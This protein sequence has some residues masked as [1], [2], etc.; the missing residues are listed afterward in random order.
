MDIINLL[1]GLSL[2]GIGFLTK[3]SPNLIAGYNTMP[4]D[5]K[6]NVDIEGLSTYLRN[7]FI[8]IG[9]T[10]IIGYFLF[11]WI[12]FQMIANS[13]IFISILLGVIILVIFAQ[14]YDHNKENK[15]RRTY[16]ILGIVILSVLGLITY[17][18]VPTKVIVSNDNVR[19]KGIYGFEMR[20]SDIKNIELTEKI[21]S[22]IMR[23]NGFGLGAIQKGTFKLNEFGKCKL[24]LNSNKNPF[25]IITDKNGLKTIINFKDSALTRDKYTE[26]KALIN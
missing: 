10:I 22:I 4:K 16:L 6:K 24:F 5:K 3:A 20:N 14:K 7:G 17:G 9:L 21:P 25:I 12:G 23:T 2:I 26:L 18:F 1:I 19:F 11:K 13:M 15:P 8:I